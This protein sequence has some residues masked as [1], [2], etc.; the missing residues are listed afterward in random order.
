MR[1]CTIVH[2]SNKQAKQN[3][4]WT[5]QSWSKLLPTKTTILESIV[6][7]I[8]KRE[9]INKQKTIPIFKS[10]YFSFYFFMPNNPF[11][12]NNKVADPIVLHPLLFNFYYM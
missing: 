6:I 3:I 2:T 12:D 7:F 10:F 4:I 8:K 5:S 11:L 9:T 1:E